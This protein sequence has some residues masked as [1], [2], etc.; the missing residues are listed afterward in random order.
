MGVGPHVGPLLAD[1][2]DVADV[3][4]KKL[5]AHFRGGWMCEYCVRTFSHRRRGG[6][7]DA[8]LGVE[9]RAFRAGDIPYLKKWTLQEPSRTCLVDGSDVETQWSTC[10]NGAQTSPVAGAEPRE[11][12]PLVSYRAS[13]EAVL[14]EIHEVAGR[15]QS[16]K[17]VLQ[18][19]TF[20]VR[21]LK[22]KQILFDW[23][24]DAVEHADM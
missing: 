23:D 17:Q 24:T 4:L 11:V 10:T 5:V 12:M 18:R 1:A 2:L 14:H 3:L 21:G 13:V 8:A 15:R 22:G 9:D 7:P 6:V 19:P 20:N 16:A